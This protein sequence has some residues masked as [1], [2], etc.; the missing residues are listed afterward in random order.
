MNLYFGVKTY[1]ILRRFATAFKSY[2]TSNI[3]ADKQR[4]LPFIKFKEF[5]FAAVYNNEK[6]AT[7]SKQK[8]H[9]GKAK[10]SLVI[11]SFRYGNSLKVMD[12]SF[13]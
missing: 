8:M 1:Q 6:K 10:R 2:R 12:T 11:L 13:A 7:K 3:C 9:R 4:D 5:G